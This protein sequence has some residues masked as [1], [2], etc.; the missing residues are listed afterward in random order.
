MLSDF[1][2]DLLH[3]VLQKELDKF[4]AD[5]LS[6]SELADKIS[7][8]KNK[9]ALGKGAEA[10]SSDAVDTMKNTMCERVME[11]RSKTEQFMEHNREIWGNFMDVL[12]SN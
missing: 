6:E 9:N 5:G 10:M 2:T 7:E 8:L 4:R 1:V 12:A 11:G 3:S